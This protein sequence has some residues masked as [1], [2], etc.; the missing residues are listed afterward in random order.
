LLF[1]SIANLMGLQN[2]VFRFLFHNGL[3]TIYILMVYKL[4][5]SN[6]KIA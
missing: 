3:V 2:T 5:K 6:L 1:Y 4:E